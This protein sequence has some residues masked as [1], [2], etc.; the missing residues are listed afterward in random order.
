MKLRKRALAKSV[1]K[2][3]KSEKNGGFTLFD[4]N[5]SVGFTYKVSDKLLLDLIKFLASSFEITSDNKRRL[6][7]APAF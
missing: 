2:R 6:R 1:G 7:Y 3:Y 5:G 4:S